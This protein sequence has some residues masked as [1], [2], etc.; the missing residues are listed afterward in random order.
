MRVRSWW[1]P[2]RPTWA[3]KWRS[4]RLV[5]S[6][7]LLVLFISVHCGGVKFFTNAMGDSEINDIDLLA[8]WNQMSIPYLLLLFLT[9]FKTALHASWVA[10]ELKQVRNTHSSFHLPGGFT[11]GKLGC[12][13]FFLLLNQ[14]LLAGK[15]CYFSKGASYFAF[16]AITHPKSIE[17]FLSFL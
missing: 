9:I 4:T 14:H 13:C 5:R 6:F 16:F 12:Y 10:E 1:R 17:I 15:V 8:R 2:P 3:W 11:T 7:L